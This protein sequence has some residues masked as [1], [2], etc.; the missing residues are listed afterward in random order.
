MKNKVLIEMGRFLI[1]ISRKSVIIY[2]TK[3][4]KK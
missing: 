2:A 4:E 3:A 1:S